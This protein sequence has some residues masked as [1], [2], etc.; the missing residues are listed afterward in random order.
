M[1]YLRAN[2]N[3]SDTEVRS[4]TLRYACDIPAQALS[5]RLGRDTYHALRDRAAAA[6]G[7]KFDLRRFHDAVLAYGSM[8]MSVLG[9]HID[10][11]IAAER[12]R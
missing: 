11:W 6:L 1:D 2:T 9:G 7:A 12:S 4:E 3:L 8:P 5:Y 10:R